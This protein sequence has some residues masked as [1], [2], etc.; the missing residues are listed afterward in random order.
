VRALQTFLEAP[1]VS[2]Q[3]ELSLL[4][5]RAF[6]EGWQASNGGGSGD[7]EVGNG[8]LDQCMA[9][10]MTPLAYSP[11]AKA[12]LST[13]GA[14]NARSQAVAAKLDEIALRY[15]A[16]Q[17]QIALAWLLTHPSGIVPLVGS[18]NP[19]HIRE[20]AGAKD[21]RLRREE[22]YELWTASWGRKVP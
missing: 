11:L 13:G 1:I 6:Y 7:G 19:E 10:N 4:Q 17:T 2:N 16:T 22:W 20:A 5:L 21:L 9:L 14:D 12:K 3:I 15:D 8:T 18:A